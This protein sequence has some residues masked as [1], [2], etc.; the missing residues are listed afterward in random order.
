MRTYTIEL[1]ADFI[2][3]SKHEI[4]L[5]MAREKARELMTCAVLLK[6]KRE[7]QVAFQTGDLFEGNKELELISDEEREE[8]RGE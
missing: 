7:P 1:R 2:D 8:M 6:D 4:L 3:E 5:G